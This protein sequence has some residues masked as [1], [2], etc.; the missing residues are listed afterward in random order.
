M[1]G[2]EVGM[3]GEGGIMANEGIDDHVT[4]L[5]VPVYS[6]ILKKLFTLIYLN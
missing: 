3:M 6:I 2:L 1:G 5:P 4:K